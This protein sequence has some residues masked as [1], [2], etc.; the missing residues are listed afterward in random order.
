MAIQDKIPAPPVTSGMM[1]RKPQAGGAMQG[2]SPMGAQSPDGRPVSP[3]RRGGR[4][5]SGRRGAHAGRSSRPTMRW[6]RMGWR[7]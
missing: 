6:L 1:A 3:D 5:H 2:R 4:L 7:R